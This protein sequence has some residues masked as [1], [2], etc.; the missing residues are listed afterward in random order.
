MGKLKASERMEQAE[1]LAGMRRDKR[2][3]G[4]VYG[5]GCRETEDAG[6]GYTQTFEN[7]DE[8]E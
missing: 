6:A 7:K 3:K 4:L 2:R 1:E 5:V 8:R